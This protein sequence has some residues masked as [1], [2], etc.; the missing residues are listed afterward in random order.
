METV[1]SQ[2]RAYTVVLC[3]MDS[4]STSKWKDTSIAAHTQYTRFY[5]LGQQ[6]YRLER[7]TQFT[8]VYPVMVPVTM[9]W[10]VFSLLMEELLPI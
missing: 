7:C 4:F 5:I 2:A 6:K 8:G 9:A 3:G 1:T 10:R